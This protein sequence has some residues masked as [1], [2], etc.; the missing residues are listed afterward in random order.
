M[1]RFSFLILAVTL[2][3]CSGNDGTSNN[4]QSADVG[5]D[6]AMTPRDTG[7]G[8]TDTGPQ[9]DLSSPDLGTP[10]EGSADT[11]TDA[12]PDDTGAGADAADMG[13]EADLEQQECYH[14]STDP[15]CPMGEFG[16]GTFLD[17]VVIAGQTECCDDLNGDGTIDNK[18]GQYVT[19]LRSQGTDINERIGVAIEAGELIY[20]LEYAHWSNETTDSDVTMHMYLGDDV[21]FDFTDN[22]AG[23]GQFLIEP[24]SFDDD[25]DAK[26][27][28][29]T[30][31]VQNGKLSAEGGGLQLVFPDLLDEVRLVVTN[32]SV[33]ADV[34]PPAD[35]QAGGT[36]AL[37]NGELSGVLD[38]D[39]FYESMNE[40]AVACECL[41]KPVFVYDANSDTWVCDV[42]PADEDACLTSPSTGCQFLSNNQSCQFFELVS[43]DVD[44]DTD[45]DGV[46]D[47]FSVG[48]RFTGIGASITGRKP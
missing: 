7:G 11:G 14:P 13:E 32:V 9:P 36:V 22:L 47:G 19:I 38:R 6:A 43:S 12:A 10:D 16:A 46:D 17:S 21:D 15:S 48:A 40:A 39:L 3:G 8:G 29:A 18:I 34:I 24:E 5:D 41:L 45:G 42:A 26:W 44:V 30:T 27:P 20:L 33:T 2:A 28:F 1:R 35:L 4:G 37:A 23:T 31:R 25:G